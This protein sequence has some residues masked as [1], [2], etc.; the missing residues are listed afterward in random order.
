MTDPLE[1]M[2]TRVYPENAFGGFTRCDSTVAYYGRINAVADSDAV[3]LDVGC[4]RGGSFVE[5]DGKLSY[6]VKLRNFKDRVG[7]VIGIDVDDTGSENTFLDEFRLIE[8]LDH[9]PVE[10]ASVDVLMA[11]F[12]ME[13]VADPAAFLSEAARV[14]RPG[15]C[16]A[17]R[18]PNRWSYVSIAAS[19][20]PNRTH[21]AVTS[22]VQA[23]RNEEDVFPVLYRCNTRR[24]L[25]KAM[26]RAGFDSAVWT[27]EAEPA[28]LSFSPAI[29]RLGS[30]IH[31]LMPP[32]FRTTL[33]AFG[34]RRES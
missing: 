14:V 16:I 24:T 23:S 18:T 11:D 25:R 17:L 6:R 9:W 31:A 8:K 30:L 15:G 34:H 32:V 33:L 12:V 22:K 2:K 1:I 7:K 20:L 10:D 29:Y 21:G 13:H 5:T 4:G 19:I 28:Y 27:M 26:D 3:V